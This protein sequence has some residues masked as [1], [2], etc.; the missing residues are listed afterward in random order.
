[1]KKTCV[2]RDDFGKRR[3]RVCG[4]ARHRE[5]RSIGRAMGLRAFRSDGGWFLSHD[6][7]DG[8]WHLIPTLDGWRPTARAKRM[9]DDDDILCCYNRC[10]RS[11]RPSLDRFVDSSTR[12]LDRGGL[13]DDRR[14]DLEECFS[15]YSPTRSDTNPRAKRPRSHRPKARAR[16]LKRRESTHRP[17]CF[18]S[19]RV[20][21]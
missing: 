7:S 20:S 21:R 14:R 19:P 12:S 2:V 17:P 18:H 15:D 8:G 9:N 10:R 11:R 16:R 13:T 6:S 3:A 5:G 1:V 4:R